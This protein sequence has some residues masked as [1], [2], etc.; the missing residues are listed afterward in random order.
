MVLILIVFDVICSLRR[1]KCLFMSNESWT[2]LLCQNLRIAPGSGYGHNISWSAHGQRMTSILNFGIMRRT[3]KAV[4]SF[5][6]NMRWSSPHFVKF[7]RK[8][9]FSWK[10]TIFG[11]CSVKKENN[12]FLAHCTL[13]SKQFFKDGYE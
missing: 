9:R 6:S 12:C 2:S 7:P 8:S 11:I 4:T 10:N 13:K 1:Q 5:K 3:W